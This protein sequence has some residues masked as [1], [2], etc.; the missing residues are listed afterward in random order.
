MF[1]IKNFIEISRELYRNRVAA[2]RDYKVKR[3]LK[4][5]SRAASDAL[6][7]NGLFIIENYFTIEECNSIV[8]KIDALWA[9]ASEKKK[10]SI[11]DDCLNNPKNKRG[12]E[13]EG[14]YNLWIDQHY[15]DHRIVG[16]EKIHHLV[17]KFYNDENILNF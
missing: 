5:F 11:H 3:E 16:A 2:T 4:Y 12:I 17:K 8:E 14:G 1:S 15:S 13:Q 10:T 7:K 9:T 6:E